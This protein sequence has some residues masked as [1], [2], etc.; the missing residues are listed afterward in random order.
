[1]SSTHEVDI[2]KAIGVGS[3]FSFAKELHSS[4]RSTEVLSRHSAWHI[5]RTMQ[6][7]ESVAE[8]KATAPETLAFRVSQRQNQ[9]RQA[10]AQVHPPLREVVEGMVQNVDGDSVLCDLFTLRPPVQVNLPALLF[11]EGVR[12]G[13]TFTLR[14]AEVDGVRS[15][16]VHM[17]DLAPTEEALQIHAQLEAALAHF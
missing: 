10:D 11:P 1:M 4:Y 17:V 3:V 9:Q 13:S 15:P 12:Y 5:P 7:G 6:V 14:L 16:V 8:P 2:P